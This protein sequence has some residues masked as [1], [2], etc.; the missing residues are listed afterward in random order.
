M[1][2]Y[3]YEVKD[4]EKEFVYQLNSDYGYEIVGVNSEPLTME[5]VNNCFGCEA[6][7]T[8]GF[9]RCD[10]EMMKLLG[11]HGTKYFAT[12]T[13]GYNHVDLLSA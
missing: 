7:S 2:I 12:R 13:V 5:N 1:R 6:V 8:L 3:F 9:S 11:N 4:Y 10:A